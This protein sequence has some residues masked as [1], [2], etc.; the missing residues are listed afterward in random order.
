MLKGFTVQKSPFG[1]AAL[2][3]PLPGT[4]PA[5]HATAATLPNGLSP[6]PNSNGHAI[7]S[8]GAVQ[9]SSPTGAKW[10]TILCFISIVVFH[11]SSRCCLIM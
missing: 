2:T 11:L 1:H 3:P 9:N 7:T 5:M 10:S 6:D 8:S 4:M